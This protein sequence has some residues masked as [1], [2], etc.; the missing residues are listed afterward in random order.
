MNTIITESDLNGIIELE[1]SVETL[2]GLR[3]NENLILSIVTSLDKPNKNLRH[4][5]Q[6][7]LEVQRVLGKEFRHEILSLIKQLENTFKTLKAN[8]ENSVAIF[9]RVGEEPICMQVNL[10]GKIE[11]KIYLDFYPAI[12][13]LIEKKDVYH[14][15]VVVNL[16]KES[17]HIFQVNAGAITKNLM[18]ENLDVNT[19]V[20]R[21]ISKERYVN[22]Q[23]ERGVRF[24]KE[25]IG[26]IDSIIRDTGLDH[27]ILAGDKNMTSTFREQLPSHLQEKV[28]DQTLDKVHHSFE[29]ILRDSIKTF[30]EEEEKESQ[31]TMNHLKHV[32][33][34]GGLAVSGYEDVQEALDGKRLD[35]LVI[36]K[37]CPETIAE[38]V[39]REAVNQKI[40]IETV[41]DEELLTLYDGFAGF[42]R[43]K[44][45]Q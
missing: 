2:A 37:E 33:A 15:Y 38:P 36:S 13:D 30:V 14:R 40:D 44:V 27:I 11:D 43:Y 10:P 45:Y 41:S 4:L 24:V 23:K 5:I 12:F 29:D 21:K 34:T 8:Q 9:I 20:G 19:N 18:S 6:M 7:S 22:H 25:K 26:I 1:K 16:S 35:L 32:L 39:I 17:A 28:L 3:D 42:T 31:A